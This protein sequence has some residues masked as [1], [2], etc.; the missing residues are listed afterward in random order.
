MT[1]EQQAVDQILE[2]GFSFKTSRTGILRLFG[3]TKQYHVK[4]PSLG[5]LLRIA[6]IAH[7]LELDEE[8]LS[9]APVSEAFAS[10]AKNGKKP[11]KVLAIALCGK[12]SKYGFLVWYYTYVLQN[13]LTPR[14]LFNAVSLLVMASDPGS[15]LNTIR[16]IGQTRTMTTPKNLSPEEHGG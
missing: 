4:P 11:A 3:K 8:K 15:F 14:Q 13:E 5:T 1:T 9:E 12:R 7:G 16:L 6:K 10:I 2:H